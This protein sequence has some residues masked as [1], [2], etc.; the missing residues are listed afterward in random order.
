MS[1]RLI[2]DLSKAKLPITSA[3]KFVLYCLAFYTNDDKEGACYPSYHTIAEFTGYSRRGV[4]K[5][6]DQLCFM[7]LLTKEVDNNK[8]NRYKITLPASEPGSL[9]L[10]NP[11]HPPSEPGSPNLINDLIINLKENIIKESDSP[12][13]VSQKPSSS[14]LLDTAKRLVDFLR[15]KTGRRY[16]Y[17][18]TTLKPILQRLKEGATEIECKQVIIRKHRDW[19]HLKDMEKY[20]RPSTLFRKENFESKYL[21]ECVSEVEKKEIMD[22]G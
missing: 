19:G 2:L 10:V 6:I 15:I 11:A 22:G 12:S 8:S 5:I 1:I 14:V 17:K 13:S 7:K 9:A 20:L 3:Q 21:P 4:I 16:Q 18:D